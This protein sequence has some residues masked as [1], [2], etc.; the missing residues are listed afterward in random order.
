MMKE[1]VSNN[2]LRTQ[3]VELGEQSVGKFIQETQQGLTFWDGFKYRSIASRKHLDQLERGLEIY[4][5][6][7]MKHVE[8]NLALTMSKRQGELFEVYHKAITGISTRVRDHAIE[9]RDKTKEKVL[10][11][12]KKFMED[13]DS[14]DAEISS[15]GIS[16]QRAQMLLEANNHL[17]Q[18]NHESIL[19]EL[20]TELEHYTEM[21]ERI[22][23]GMTEEIEEHRM[24]DVTPR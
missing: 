11:S 20:T 21:Y 3:D 16:A 5:D 4:L 22:F 9:Y 15:S 18:K 17:T 24:K 1:Q 14:F 23:I 6:K 12:L 7:Q 19:R 13:A 2:D 8:Y 10:T